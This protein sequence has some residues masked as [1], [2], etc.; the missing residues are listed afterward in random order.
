LDGFSSVYKCLTSIQY[1]SCCPHLQVSLQNKS[2]FIVHT[3]LQYSHLKVYQMSDFL[4]KQFFNVPL[5]F[6]I[7]SGFGMSRFQLLEFRLYQ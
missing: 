4:F 7:A 3:V 2:N 1:L 5:F 6:Q